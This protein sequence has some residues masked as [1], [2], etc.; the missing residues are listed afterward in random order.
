MAV[1]SSSSP[2]VAVDGDERQ[3]PRED[4]QREKIIGSPKDRQNS[5]STTKGRST[6][7]LLTRQNGVYN[8]S[9]TNSI[10]SIFASKDSPIR[11]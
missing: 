1:S 11:I 3:R 7:C 4:E 5:Y 9:T 2:A 6:I 10:M 8:H